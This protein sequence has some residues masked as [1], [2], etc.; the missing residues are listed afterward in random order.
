MDIMIYERVHGRQFI[1]KFAGNFSSIKRD[2]SPSFLM[3][4]HLADGKY[5][6]TK[7]S[8][9]WRYDTTLY[10]QR[11]ALFGAVVVL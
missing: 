11:P 2:K 3:E 10:M 8:V 6:L 1:A 5:V 9:G 4:M 7:D